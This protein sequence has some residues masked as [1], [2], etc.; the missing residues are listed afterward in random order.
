[1]IISP[2]DYLIREDGHYE[3][4]REQVSRAWARAIREVS[5]LLMQHDKI[6]L[7]VGLPAAGKTTWLWAP[8]NQESGVL[9]VDATFVRRV[10]RRPFLK[11]A[12]KAGKPIEA[13]I[14]DTPW[15]TIL[16]RNSQR[17]SLRAPEPEK[18]RKWRE[19]LQDTP[20]SEEEGFSRVT[21]IRS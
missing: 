4:S 17:S 15:E 18:L 14:F 10:W 12:K 2:D 20:P 6:V 1:V 9:Y 11:A 8:G 21:V 16:D 7:L 13:I 19:A 5:Y 3:W